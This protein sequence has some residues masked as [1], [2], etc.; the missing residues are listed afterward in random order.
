MA[1]I[2]IRNLDDSLRTRLRTQAALHGRSMEDEALDILRA[3][4]SREATQPGNLA[5][6]IR[7]WVA[8]LGGVD[9]P[10]VPREPV[11]EPPDFGE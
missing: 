9:L 10:A 5:A 7:A 6:S 8:S 4:L 2:I 1:S 3:S 11:R